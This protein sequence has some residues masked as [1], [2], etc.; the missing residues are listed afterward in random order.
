MNL[1]DNNGQKLQ[2]L[3]FTA[4]TIIKVISRKKTGALIVETGGK[5]VALCNKFAAAID[6]E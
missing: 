4:G 2:A 5:Q 3:G 1:Q 6:I